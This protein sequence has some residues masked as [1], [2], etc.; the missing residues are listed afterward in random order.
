MKLNKE[1]LET[2][3]NLILKE[4]QTVRADLPKYSFS[5]GFTEIISK[6]ILNLKDLNSLF[7][8]EMEN[9]QNE[10]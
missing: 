7:Y 5:E 2:L 10:K 4:M 6:E 8:D 3:S 1:Q 9:L